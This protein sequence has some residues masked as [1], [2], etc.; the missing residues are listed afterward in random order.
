M[1]STLTTSTGPTAQDRSFRFPAENVMDGSEALTIESLDD[2]RMLFCGLGENCRAHVQGRE[3]VIALVLT[4]MFAD[5]HVLLEDHPGSGK[6]TLARA[7][8]DSIA[9][10][11]G[12]QHVASF[13]RIQ[14][15]PDLLPSDVT[16]GNMFDSASGELQFRAGPLFANVV[17]ADEINRTS[18]KVQ[19]ALLEAMAE[20]QVTVDNQTH[21]LADLFFVLA[22]QNPLDLAGTY[23]LPRAQLDRFLFKI[24]MA[25]LSRSHQLEVLSRRGKR[26]VAVD[27]AGRFAG[28]GGP[29]AKDRDRTGRNSHA[30]PRVPRRFVGSARPRSS[31]A[32]RDFDPFAGAGPAGLAD[33]GHATR[34]ELRHAPRR[35]RSGSAVVQPP[36]GTGT[37]LAGSRAGR[38]RVRRADY[39]G[40]DPQDAQSLTAAY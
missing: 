1:I 26:G 17:L 8:G 34:A 10:H 25:Q 4:A 7:L 3:N 5:G 30:D 13:R 32:A 36:T 28:P 15:T 35:S 19:A 39:R 33:L 20:K 37:R 16:G 2:V 38:P 27:A 9:P 14:F 12:D 23:P 11:D 24:K 40:D 6:T 21:R 29:C 18:P 22:T 31:R